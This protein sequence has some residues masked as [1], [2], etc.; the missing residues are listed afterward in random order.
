MEHS[1]Q[2]GWSVLEHKYDQGKITVQSLMLFTQNLPSNFRSPFRLEESKKIISS[3]MEESFP[4][5]SYMVR[6]SDVSREIGTTYA[7]DGGFN[8]RLGYQITQYTKLPSRW[9][10]HEPGDIGFRHDVGFGSGDFEDLE[11]SL[12]AYTAIG[13]SMVEPR[14]HGVLGLL[15]VAPEITDEIRLNFRNHILPK[16]MR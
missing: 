12:Q 7:V 6:S 10:I 8:V 14:L 15:M 2:N 3:L 4:E 16:N 13:R 11:K 5:V 1:V 9:S